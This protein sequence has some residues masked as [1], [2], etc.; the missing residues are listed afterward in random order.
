MKIKTIHEPIDK[1]DS[2]VNSHLDQG[3]KILPNSFRVGDAFDEEGFNNHLK[4][5]MSEVDEIFNEHSQMDFSSIEKELDKLDNKSEETMKNNDFSTEGYIIV[6][7][8]D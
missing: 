3:W 7:Y 4:E 5:E 2:N 6:L 8:K 1:F